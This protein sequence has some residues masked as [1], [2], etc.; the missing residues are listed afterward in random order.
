MLASVVS[1]F[2]GVGSLVASVAG[3][4][5]GVVQTWNSRHGSA[6]QPAVERVDPDRAAADG[7]RAHLGRQPELPRMGEPASRTLALRAV[8]PAIRLHP[9]TSHPADP[10]VEATG[11][12][13]RR[14]RRPLPWRWLPGRSADGGLDPDLP[15]FVDRDRGPEITARMKDAARHG[16]FLVLV[17]DSSVGKTRLLYETAR[18]ELPDFA[19]LAPDRGDGEL[20]NLLGAASSPLPCP[21][22]IWLDELHH[23]L[24]GPYLD[25]GA[26]PI[27]AD[28]V[29]RLLD[30]PT[31]VV[32][33]GSLWPEHIAPLHATTTDPTTGE[34]KARYP[35]SVVILNHRRFHQLGVDTFS[36]A[37]HAAAARLA[38]RD[39]RLD[40]ALADRRFG[41]TEA[42]AGAP[43]L[44]Y[45]YEQLTAEQQAVLHAAI[46]ARRLGIH[47]PLTRELLSVAARGYLTR[48]HTDNTWFEASI[49]ELTRIE[50]A[51][52]PLLEVANPDHSMVLGYDV[53]DYLFQQVKAQR[54]AQR[55]PAVAWQAFLAHT[56]GPADIAGLADAADRRLLYRYAEALWRRLLAIDADNTY[57][58]TY[59]AQ[60]LA[61]LLVNRDGPADEVIAAFQR[62]INA[63][64]SYDHR[65]YVNG[66]TCKAIVNRLDTQGRHNVVAAILRVWADAG[67]EHATYAWAKLLIK[68]ERSDQAVAIVQSLVNIHKEHT[69][70]FWAERLLRQDRLDE[71]VTVIRG[72][73]RIAPVKAYELGNR[74]ASQCR[75]RQVRT[76]AFWIPP[77]DERG[78]QLVEGWLDRLV[79]LGRV[80]D[81]LTAL[82]A[83]A[84]ASDNANTILADLLLDQGR[85]EKA[86]E[87]LRDRADDNRRPWYDRNKSAQRLA[88]LLIDH[89]RID[90]LEARADRGDGRAALRLAELLIDQGRIKDLQ[91]RV[92]DG[93][94]HAANSLVGLLE[95]QGHLEEAIG[96]QRSLATAD[97]PF[98]QNGLIRLLVEQGSIEEA[99][100]L[101]RARIHAGDDTAAGWL[102]DL[103]RE[104]NAAAMELLC[105]GAAAGQLGAAYEL[106]H[107]LVDQDRTDQTIPLPG[108][109]ALAQD[110][111]RR[112]QAERWCHLLLRHGRT[113]QAMMALEAAADAG[114]GH[115][116]LQLAKLHVDQ[117]HAKQAAAV[118]R[119][120]SGTPEHTEV[121]DWLNELSQ[122]GRT[123]QAI[124]MLCTLADAKE[125]HSDLH[126]W[127]DVWLAEL[128]AKLGRIDELRARADNADP[129]RHAAR[130]L[131]GLLAKL[132]C[133]EELRARGDRGNLW[134]ASHAADLLVEQNRT[135][136]ALALLRAHADAGHGYA[137][138]QLAQLLATH[139]R[140][141]ELRTRADA[142]D[143][144]AAS[145]LTKLLAER[146]D[147]DQLWEELAAGTP[148]TADS[149]AGVLEA[150]GQMQQAERLRRYGL[151]PD[152]SIAAAPG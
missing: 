11:P 141:I 125:W 147:L 140:V 150:R 3:L 55:V 1:M 16:G 46:D 61:D 43:H 133:I 30:A 76:G 18:R 54:R 44:M 34:S 27:S 7:L 90:E 47:S 123:E 122:Q 6:R 77:E 31:P 62:L 148:Y 144:E 4:L 151:D 64:R 33:L 60:R 107:L 113:E 10:A 79:G 89:N 51:T 117:G 53:A 40:Q 26:T 91:A 99:I 93:D 9:P 142:G 73:T 88:D 92:N 94:R 52:A 110:E 135:D 116:A 24:D 137:A 98:T 85:A 50:L 41:V 131:A 42:L 103:A 105:E 80:D 84:D 56:H 39:P 23:F 37:E 71:A 21:L 49:V 111:I 69:V 102:A 74:L 36:N 58:A 66:V 121:E 130:E 104:G 83:L 118:I 115:A 13:M 68:Q 78:W 20:V 136:E 124:T 87:I 138:Q 2:V 95:R 28:A 109:R 114:N 81:A 101:L 29:R 134:A 5:L 17:G 143:W 32:L 38:R 108:L 59:A 57:A 19:V 128:L 129:Y 82:R 70:E 45:R 15:L 63:G 100:E 152:G 75:T 22:I 86:F 48:V 96:V 65:V 14:R 145:A 35:D 149:L 67:D 106:A 25:S 8:H 126:P 146:R 119:G 12:G 120:C 132:G 97:D 139:G 127:A 72:Y 112:G